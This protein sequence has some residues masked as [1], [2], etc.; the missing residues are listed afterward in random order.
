M[1]QGPSAK[2]VDLLARHD[3]ATANQVERMAPRVRKLA[4][5][6]PE[7][8]SVW[9]DAL[10]QAGVLTPYQ[11]AQINAGRGESLARGAYVLLHPIASPYY[12]ACFAARARGDKRVVRLYVIQAQLSPAATSAGI[13]EWLERSKLLPS[14]VTGRVEDAGCSGADTWAACGPV[15]GLTAA[16]WMVENGRFPPAAVLQIAR[17]M[18]KQLAE[19]DRAGLVHGDLSAAGLLLDDAGHVAAPLPGFRGIVRP[20]EGYSFNDLA[21]ESYDYLA[22]ERVADGGPPARASDLYAC[23]CLWWHLLTGR[24]PF[25]G[26]NALAKLK[27]VHAAKAT[28][29]KQLAPDTPD[30]LARA[31]EACM[32][33]DPSARPSSYSELAAML[34]PTTR[35]GAAI[36]ARCVRH[37]TSTW[38][39]RAVN[40]KDARGS[41][42]PV[43]SCATA[44]ILLVLI[45]LWP[46][47]HSPAEREPKKVAQKQ[48]VT[49]PVKQTVPAGPPPGTSSAS[50]N[51][52]KSQPIQLTSATAAPSGPPDL[53]LDTGA[54]LRIPKL[55]LKRGQRVR[56]RGGKRAMLVLS[57]QPLEVFA[58]IGL[59]EGIDFVW[60]KLPRGIEQASLSVHAESLEFRDCSFRGAATRLQPAIVWAGQEHLPIPGY[61][62]TFVNCVAQGFAAAMD[63]RAV[64]NLTIE[65]HNSLFVDSGPLVRMPN[66]AKA[67]ESVIISLDR[68]TLRGNGS[69]A[70]CRYVRGENQPGRTSINATDC[71]MDTKAALLIF[72]GPQQPTAFVTAT[73]WA[74]EGAFIGA[75][76]IVAAWRAGSGGW[77]ELPEEDLDF[78]GAARCE[79]E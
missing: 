6:L 18:L 1:Q 33:R 21:V 39:V 4:G 31:I 12:A 9:I 77:Q 13:A 48:G 68:V 71:V 73:S 41:K 54:P 29:V 28:P 51:E 30:V 2:L 38:H 7:F 35:A 46:I 63:F 62:L 40:A 45:G 5:E 37:P 11:A 34:G 59:F 56:G 65:A 58:E 57:D 74:G 10:A 24:A 23:G 76:T 50:T 61:E 15:T 44:A 19:L 79:L 64:G 47:W 55:E 25:A 78:G 60:E 36:V 8:D 69:V 49:I 26:G 20:S 53:L 14:T 43:A 27:A 17:E 66:A 72:L 32:A 75:S 70:E 52:A 22:P 42:V 67:Q 3:L 16:D